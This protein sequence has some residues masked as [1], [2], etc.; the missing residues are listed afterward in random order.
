[1][2][3]YLFITILFFK[4]AYAQ[5]D[6]HSLL[7]ADNLV[8]LKQAAKMMVSG[9]QNNKKNA[10]L[11][12][13]I[14]WKK[15]KITAL[16]SNDIDA[17]SWACKAL[18]A[19]GNGR[20]KSLLEEIYQSNTHKKLRK[21]A[22]KSLNQ[23]PAGPV[24]QFQ[25]GVV[26]SPIDEKIDEKTHES[27]EQ[28]ITKPEVL[29][30]NELE[31]HTA[32]LIPKASLTL[33]ERMLFAIAKGEWLAIKSIA[34]QLY[35]QRSPQKNSQ[36]KSEVKLVDALSQF[37]LEHYLD[38]LDKQQIDVLAWVCR[39]IGHSNHGRYTKLMKQVS[40][41]ASA[42]KIR[43]Y[44]AI[45]Y[46]ASPPSDKSSQINQIDFSALLNEFKAQ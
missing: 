20:Y 25:G 12:A 2:R 35:S 36:H 11:L 4:S 21:Y 9:Q 16:S 40:A 33:Q 28:S 42:D 6:V 10:D 26:K 27:T 22:K 32:F 19:T 46:E 15:Y 5:T 23:L 31:S 7:L 14:L 34:Q 17:L 44:A 29:T 30:N 3:V 38:E 8:Q 45:A 37:L 43:N 1:M 13:E 41:K 24:K 18:A 39:A